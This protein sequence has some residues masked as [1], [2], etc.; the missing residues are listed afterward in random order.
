MSFA[1]SRWRWPAGGR[2]IYQTTARTNSY[3]AHPLAESSFVKIFCS[4]RDLRNS[5]VS[6]VASPLS[7]SLLRAP[8]SHGSARHHV[9]NPEE[10][11]V[12]QK[13]PTTSVVQLLFLF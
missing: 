8:T 13:A 1:A 4:Q 11:A 3:D 12:G 2:H 5:R 10:P 6:R 9:L 7:L